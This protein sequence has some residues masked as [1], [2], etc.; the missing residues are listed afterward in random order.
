MVDEQQRTGANGGGT[1]RGGETEEP[2]FGLRPGSLR[3]ARHAE[4]KSGHCHYQRDE[5]GVPH[6]S[7][8]ATKESLGWLLRATIEITRPLRR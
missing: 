7:L 8:L 4:T 3:A 5:G 1:G 2:W 6:G